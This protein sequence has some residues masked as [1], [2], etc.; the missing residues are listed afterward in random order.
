LIG[1]KDDINRGRADLV[2]SDTILIE[3]IFPKIA[4][5]STSTSPLQSDP[6]M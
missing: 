6:S 3:I 2:I 1:E 4:G 5:K